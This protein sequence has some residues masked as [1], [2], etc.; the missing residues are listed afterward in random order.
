MELNY[1]YDFLG[2]CFGHFCEGIF[3]FPSQMFE[4]GEGGTRDLRVDGDWRRKLVE[5][6]ETP[7]S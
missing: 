6:R 3:C 5:G 2:E 7:E 1:D 4:L